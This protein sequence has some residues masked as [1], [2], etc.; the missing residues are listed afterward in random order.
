MWDKFF[1]AFWLSCMT[2][3][4]MTCILY[5]FRLTNNEV[6]MLVMGTNLWSMEAVRKIVEIRNN[7]TK[8][9]GSE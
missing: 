4:G 9:R 8:E 5:D 2:M 1:I 3:L 6:G 7:T